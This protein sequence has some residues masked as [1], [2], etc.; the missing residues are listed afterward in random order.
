MFDSPQAQGE[1]L[2]ELQPEQVVLQGAVTRTIA[3][4][5]ISDVQAGVFGLSFIHDGQLMRLRMPAKDATAW[6]P[7]MRAPAPD[8]ARLLGLKPGR[9][10]FI[11]GEP[12]AAT[13]QALRGRVAADA[14]QADM[15]LLC[16]DDPTSA[17]RL[18]SVIAGLDLHKTVW[19]VHGSGQEPA[20]LEA[21][22]RAKGYQSRRSEPWQDGRTARKFGLGEKNSKRRGR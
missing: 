5:E 14:A 7:L 12:D 17:H 8:I 20:P 15:T 19:L 4:R 13:A 3:L 9:Q 18:A 2:A 22:L 11:A 1:V 10:V 21:A 16:L 6:Q